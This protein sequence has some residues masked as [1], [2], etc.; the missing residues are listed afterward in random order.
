MSDQLK[1]K[2]KAL[3]LLDLLAFKNL[4]PNRKKI[5][6]KASAAP[7]EKVPHMNALAQ[8]I[9][10]KRQTFEITGIKDCPNDVK[11]YELKSKHAAF[12]RAGQYLSVKL[13]I[14]GYKVT[15]AYS[16]L[17]SPKE[18]LTGKCALGIKGSGFV[19][20][21][22]ADNWKVGDTITTSGP[23]GAFYYEE[24]RD[25]KTVVGIA[26]GCGISPLYSMA[27]AIVDGTEDFKLV[28]LYGSRTKKDIVLEAELREI[29]S[30][31]N[32]KVKV[33]HVLSEQEAKG[34]ET[35]FVTKELISKY[36]GE[37]PY[38][39]FMC[40]PQE[41]YDFVQ[42]EIEELGLEK[43]YVRAELY[44]QINNIQEYDKFPSEKEGRKYKMTILAAG[45][46]F[47][48]LASSTESVL[49]AIERAKVAAP[50][51]CRT[52]EC[53]FC[54]SRLISGDVFI[55]EDTDGRRAADKQSGYIH[56]CASFPVSDIVIEVPVE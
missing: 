11:I 36:G 14:K 9:H 32:G 50:S 16:I 53:G 4:V 15:R 10:P 49:V 30:K 3:G 13:D 23:E 41:M 24:L 1:V 45:K 17:S 26:G 22:I 27:Q 8:S 47:E 44:G 37:L 35:G 43:K 56:P 21:Y 12:F 40:G 28:L 51:L 5:F 19:S 34:C 48:T 6:E 42:K 7:V 29:V 54:R 52:G 20:E 18:A 33:V 38:S 39:I 25:A 46:T 55:P 31:S 2:V